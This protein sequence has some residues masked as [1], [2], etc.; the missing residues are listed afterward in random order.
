VE[1]DIRN[2]MEERKR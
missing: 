2:Y 1:E